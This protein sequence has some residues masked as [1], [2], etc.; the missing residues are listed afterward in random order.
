MLLETTIKKS[1]FSSDELSSMECSIMNQC[2]TKEHSG[3]GKV[4]CNMHTWNFYSDNAKDIRTK[5]E[6]HIPN[7]TIVVK[8]HILESFYPYEIHTDVNHSGSSKPQYTF[9]IPLEDY[10]S[11]TFVF[12]EYDT[13]SNEFEEFKTKYNGEIKLRITKEEEFKLSMKMKKTGKK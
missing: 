4:Y 6:K 12:N 10:D 8:S 11:E 3:D 1:V 9:I 2:T 5:L 7:G 13:T